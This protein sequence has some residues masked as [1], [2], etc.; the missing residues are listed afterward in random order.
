MSGWRPIFEV[1]RRDF[2]QRGRSRV[3]LFGTI[4]IVMVIVGG[5]PLLAGIV[6]E[7]PPIEIGIVGVPSSELTAALDGTAGAMEVRYALQTY[8][9]LSAAE[10]AL[11]SG[12]VAAVINDDEIIWLDEVGPVTN[13]L[14]SASVQAARRDTMVESLGLPPDETAALFNPP[15]SVL[16]ETPDPEKGLRQGAA[17]AG[18]VVLFMS[19]VLFGQFVLLGV[20]EEKSS[21][22]AEVVL[23]RVRPVELL[24][25][26]VIGIGLLGLA[27]LLVVGSAV[28][29][30]FQII[31]VA[32][33][34]NLSSIGVEVILTVVAWY[35]LGY[36][37]YSVVYAAAGSL[38]SRQE[39]VQGVSW[40]PLIGL[41]PGYV[42]ALIASWSPEDMVVRVASMLPGTAPLV[43]PVRASAADVPLWEVALAVA[44]TLGSTYLL[45]QLAA[46]IYRGGILRGGRV[47]MREAWRSTAG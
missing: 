16:L 13:A 11:H 38:V 39:D 15:Q 10:G 27:Q 1:A 17:Y 33:L 44:V 26:K 32:E 37:L 5:G 41:L 24:A 36:A 45:I 6:S 21:R 8:P 22:V 14:V 28:M 30:M 31:D 3:L 9:T 2:V 12:E 34:P 25:G 29:L 4:A 46:R 19:V 40:I 43:M 47:R 23:S 7:P 20:L 42:I 35:V 18:A